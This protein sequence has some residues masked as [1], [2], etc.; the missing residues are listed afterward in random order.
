MRISELF[1]KYFN[2]LEKTSNIKEA[3]EKSEM[4][5][6]VQKLDFGFFPLG[7]GIFIDNKSNLEIAEIDNCEI[8]V[9]GNDFGTEKYIIKKCPNN[10]ERKSNPTIRNLLELKMNEKTTF[11]TNL[12]LGLRNGDKMVGVKKLQKEYLNFCIDF[13]KIQLEFI[14]P[15]V[16]LCLG[17]EVKK[18]LIEYSRDFTDISKITITN[19]YSDENKNDFTLMVNGIKFI[20]IPHPSFAHINWT[21][22]IKNRINETIKNAST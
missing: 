5:M 9:L 7:S 8:M 2:E 16:V 4:K 22:N 6:E 15:K 11:Y 17:N 10:K 19:L 13:F 20:F 18:A 21:N 1:K 3:F 14:N 12:F